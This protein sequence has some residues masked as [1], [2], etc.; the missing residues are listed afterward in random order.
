MGGQCA[1]VMS[2]EGVR[3]YRKKPIS[4]ERQDQGRQYRDED[5]PAK[6]GRIAVEVSVNYAEKTSYFRI[7]GAEDAD[8][9]FL[10]NSSCWPLQV[11]RV[12]RALLSCS[13][14]IPCLIAPLFSISSLLI[15]YPRTA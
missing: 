6:E 13:A 1:D 4:L 8:S 11:L 7:I 3:T 12:F 10:P 14:V 5:R 9:V 15:L 2:G